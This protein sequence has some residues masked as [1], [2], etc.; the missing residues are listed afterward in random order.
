MNSQISRSGFKAWLRPGRLIPILTILGAGI[1][2]VLSLLNIIALT[3]AENIIVALLALLAVDALTE[4]LSILE[5]LD[6]KMRLIS[7]NEGLRK[8]SEIPL[9]EEQAANAYEI[10][11]LAVSAISLIIRYLSFFENILMKGSSIRV[12]LLNPGSESLN[13]WKLQM[14]VTTTVSDIN[15]SLEMLRGIMQ[16][17]DAKGECEIRLS[18]VFVPF[19]MVATD[20]HHES[21]S[22]V[23]EYH[24]YRTTLSERPHI[25]LAPSENPYWFNFY[26]EQFEQLWSDSKLWSPD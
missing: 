6:T 8:R 14:K 20:I 7:F 22:M 13:A 11:I 3:I 10:C 5:R 18:E 19:S 1:A 26:R 15:S 4:R 23:V 17:T 12:I 2:L 21:G 24:T 9:V 16:A 25:L